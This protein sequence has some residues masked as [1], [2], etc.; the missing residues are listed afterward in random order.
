MCTGPA[1]SGMQGALSMLDCKFSVSYG[2]NDS[3]CVL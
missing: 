2:F 1:I 3:I